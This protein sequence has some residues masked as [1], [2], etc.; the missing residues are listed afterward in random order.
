MTGDWREE[1]C[2]IE[3]TPGALPHPHPLDRVIKVLANGLSVG[4]STSG[5]RGDLLIVNSW[6]DLER[7]G[8][9]NAV[10]GKIVL[11]DYRNFIEYSEHAGFR[12]RGAN[13]A[14]QFGA[15]A[16]L[17]R[18]MTPNDSTSSVHTGSQVPYSDSHSHI[19][20]ACISIEDT[21]LL[22]R[23]MARGHKLV[24]ELHLPCYRL[25]DRTSRNLVFE[26]RGTD[27]EDEIVVIGGGLLLTMNILFLFPTL[28]CISTVAGH[29][30]CWDCM[31]G[32]CQGAHDD[33]QG[34]ILSIEIIRIISNLGIKPRRSIRAVCFVDEEMCQSGANAFKNAHLAELNNIVAA[35][36]TDMGLG[37]PIGFG[38]SG[39]SV[40]RKILEEILSPLSIVDGT[41]RVDESWSG[42]GVDIIPLI[43]E[44]VP[45]LLLRHEDSW[46]YR[47]YFHMHHTASDSIDHVDKNML[48]LNL[49]VLLGAVWLL[50]NSDSR[51]VRGKTSNV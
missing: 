15:S 41:N 48:T 46:W 9:A 11:Y 18:S 13:M 29:T 20:A 47:E 43:D 19:P 44:G 8:A 35:I 3:I 17:V 12:G 30:D 36:E 21:E 49:Q 26:I 2:K 39:D 23:L 4:T 16:V 51:M 24:A 22:A 5:V 50:A 34:V 27:K 10:E 42:R 45:G 37:K 31:H 33:G 40:N 1:Y 6:E 14:A 28:N 25:A 7:A 38:Y 32:A